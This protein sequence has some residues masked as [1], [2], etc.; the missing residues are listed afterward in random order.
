MAT[1]NRKKTIPKNDTN[2]QAL[3]EFASEG[4]FIAD[5]EG[6]Y[7]DVNDIGLKMLGYTRE[8]LFKLN[9][10]DLIPAEELESTL[11]KFSEIQ[12]GK[13]VLGEHHLICNDGSLLAVE[14]SA[15]ILPNG[16]LLG[17][18]RDITERKRFDAEIKRL[19]RLYEVISQINQMVVRTNKSEIIFSEACRI[20]IDHGK[21]RMAWIG[22]L[23]EKSNIIKP[24]AWSGV[25][26]GYLKEVKIIT[27]SDFSEGKGPT[28]VAIREGKYF[29]SNN[30]ATDSYMLPWR[31]EALKRGYHSSISLPIMIQGKTIGAFN[32]YASE[33]YFFNEK[34]IQH[35]LEVTNNIAFALE[36][37][38]EE[39]NRRIAEETLIN[40]LNSFMGLFNSVS[41]AIYI[42]NENGQFINVNEGAIKMYGYTHDEF[43]GNTPEFLSAP[44]KNDLLHVVELVKK[45]FTSGNP[46][47]FEFWGK[48]KNGEIFPKEVICNK[49]KYFGEDV[50]IAT[51]R[52]MTESKIAKEAL[53]ESEEKFRTIFDNASDGILLAD[54]MTR[55][56]VMANKM[57]CN[58]L[59]Y[60]YEELL[61]MSVTDI[62]P[63][64]DLPFVF[65]AFD[66]QIRNEMQVAENLP[67]KR[68]DGTV[69]F[70]DISSSPQI[71]NEKNYL[72]GVFRDVTE[73]KIAK[74]ALQKSEEKFYSIFENARDPILLLDERSQ[75]IACNKA[76]VK[77]LG[78]ESKEELLPRHPSELSP[79]YQPDGQLSSIKA[80]QMIR[81]GYENGSTQFEWVHKK[82]DGTP[83]FMDI[84]LTVIPI[85]G[86][87]ILMVHWRDI[88]I[89]KQSE[90][91]LRLSEERFKS[92][93]ELAADGILLGSPKGLII[94][95]NHQI[96][97]MTGYSEQELIGT[98]ISFLFSE[99]ELEKSPLRYDLLDLGI[100]VRNERIV[101][102]KDGSL[103]HIEMN[104]KKMPDNT[105]QAI[106]RD[107]TE[108]LKSEE[109]NR[110]IEKTEYE[111]KVKSK[112]M[113]N[114]S[115]EIRN[116]LNAIIGLNTTI[117]GTKLDPEQKKY[118]EAIDISA[119]NL[120]NILNDILDFSKIE[121][122]KS[123]LNFENIDLQELLQKI[124]LLYKQKSLEK[125]IEIQYI[126]SSD[127]PEFVFSDKNKIQQIITNLFSNAMKFTEKGSVLLSVKLINKEKDNLIIE[128][129]IKDSGIGIQQKD[130]DKI[131]QSFTQLDSSTK[132]LYAGTGLG[133]SISKNYIE[134]LGG[135]I[136]FNSKFGEG[137]E[138]KF[139]LP[140]K[141]GT[142]SVRKKAKSLGTIENFNFNS[143]TPLY[144]LVAEDDGINRLYLINLLK[145]KGFKVDFAIDGFGVMELY[146]KNKYDLI[147]MDG[148][149]PRM[150]GFEAAQKIREFEKQNNA[151]H[152]NILTISGYSMNEVGEEFKKSGI[153]DYIIKPI[154]E[155]ELFEKIKTLVNKK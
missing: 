50:I 131:F 20:A 125:G 27:A 14:I 144:I 95:A 103:V 89:R 42:Q 5:S 133:L 49:G 90:E 15:S 28:G 7:T 110:K 37:I 142:S 149:M 134:M 132:K 55:N 66:R 102:R 56:F 80:E 30:I 104:T 115:H 54:A 94:G 138:F 44:G 126:I 78:A 113:A 74:E 84:S 91:A 122:N 26:E 85:D 87:N 2:Y 8:E 45:V 123:G 33:T 32:I 47:R 17:M 88:T 151:P 6:N 46:E 39:H 117:S 116:P 34:E 3:F 62:H 86:K 24:I 43:I 112:F 10:K 136:S 9:L 31:A 107:N 53:K 23:E 22:L 73:R 83:I 70:A 143:I 82:L 76:T 64:E 109:L 71:I 121:A 140:I 67:V 145:S 63:K 29:T 75:F 99:K 59:G 36:K 19:N 130:F 155:Y 118:V 60:T 38:E 61:T 100:V 98:N 135:E 92:I 12:E 35:L 65:N 48:R 101:T 111:N 81:N 146:H 1:A 21:F 108:R 114:L 124:V 57:I 127:I 40:S 79:E 128:F 105:Y 129:S 52:D 119:S 68:K 93:I 150:D 96:C 51:A 25:E 106:I 120:L 13:I 152:T 58:M 18:V 69:F 16:S 148:Q 147:L 4:I 139:W 153:D 141:T 41:E 137:S 154:N 97:N 72:F 11:K 77:I